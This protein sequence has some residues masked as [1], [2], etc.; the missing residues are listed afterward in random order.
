M[1]YAHKRRENGRCFAT[2]HGAYRV[3]PSPARLVIGS[4][5]RVSSSGLGSSEDFNSWTRSGAAE[6]YAHK[7]TLQQDGARPQQVE[8]Q[9][10]TDRNDWYL[11]HDPESSTTTK[12][13]RS[14]STAA[15][16]SPPD[17]PHSFMRIP[18][19]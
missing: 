9:V 10:L 3:G 1:V 13:Q 4:R 5:H 6:V 8:G 7:L 15:I 16:S 11:E 14:S 2:E 12:I 17:V 18:N 19:G